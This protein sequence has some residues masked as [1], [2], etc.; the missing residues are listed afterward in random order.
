[1]CSR[2]CGAIKPVA[3]LLFQIPDRVARMNVNRLTKPLTERVVLYDAETRGFVLRY[4]A[5][6]LPPRLKVFLK[7]ALQP[8]HSLEMLRRDLPARMG[9]CKCPHRVCSS[10][11][12]RSQVP[13]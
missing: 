1:M 3:C 4:I 10:P 6:R 13:I 2:D 8:S 7:G 11:A 9:F 5:R 12:R